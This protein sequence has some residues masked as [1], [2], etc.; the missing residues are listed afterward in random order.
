MIK[1]DSMGKLL[2]MGD[3][4]YF[5]TAAGIKLGKVDKILDSGFYVG[6]EGKTFVIQ[7]NN[8]VKVESLGAKGAESKKATTKT[9]GRAINNEI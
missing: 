6:Y 2:S 5:V 3:S 1:T 7:P 4:V 8:I 9:K